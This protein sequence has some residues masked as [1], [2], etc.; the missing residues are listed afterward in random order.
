MRI[1]STTIITT[2]TSTRSSFFLSSTHSH[3]NISSIK[4]FHVDDMSVEWD[5]SGSGS[6]LPKKDSLHFTFSRIAFHGVPI[7][8]IIG[9][10]NIS[11]SLSLSPSPILL[12][13]GEDYV[14]YR[15]FE[16]D[17]WKKSQFPG[18]QEFWRR[19]RT[20][21]RLGQTTFV[22]TRTQ[23]HFTSPHNH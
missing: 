11:L 9:I 17:V 3:S 21:T 13:R 19:D 5:G 6:T 1:R 8:N 12:E 4:S 14:Q 7:L 23:N 22:L 18:F 15:K 2:S 16:L 20:R 10:S